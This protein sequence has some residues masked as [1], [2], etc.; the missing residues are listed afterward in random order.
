MKRITLFLTALLLLGVTVQA[1][2]TSNLTDTATLDTY[3][4]G[5]N[6]KAFI[7]VEDGIEFSV[8]P[9]GQ[10]DFYM[11]NYG[12]NVNAGNNASNVSISFHQF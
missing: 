7:F 10:F 9:D 3:V 11:N 5:Y 4:K 6:G 2:T 12:P 1:E 8:F